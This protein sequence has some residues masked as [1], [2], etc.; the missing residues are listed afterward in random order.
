MSFLRR[1][2]SWITIAGVAISLAGVLA[3]MFLRID[4]YDPSRYFSSL[5]LLRQIKQIDSQWEVQVLRSRIGINLDYDSLVDPLNELNKN[6]RQL[7]QLTQAAPLRNRDKW[8]HNTQ[9]YQQALAKKAELIES[10]K[11]HN[12][13]LR[14]SLH[15]LPTA[16]DDVQNLISD[17]R[18]SMVLDNTSSYVFDVL[19][20]TMEFVQVSTDDKA[21][22]VTIGLE[23][24]EE[25]KAHLDPDTADALD[26]FNQHVH[27]VLRE[28]KV[29][30]GVLNAIAAVSVA[31]RLD[32]L[33]EL[34]SQEQLMSAEQDRLHHQY[35]LVFSG[36]LAALLLYLGVR[37]ARSYGEINR[38]NRALHNANDELEARVV[39]RT[40]ELQ[41]A[42]S[43][44]VG[45]ARQAGMAEIATNVLHNVGNVL[46]SV[47][48][49][50]DL[51]ARK[52]RTSKSAGLSKA[53]AMLQEHQHDLGHFITQ[54]EKGKLLPG[55]FAQVCEALNAERESITRELELLNKSVNHIKEIVTTQQSY[56]GPSSIVEPLMMAEL[57]EDALR[58][59]AGSL[60]RHQVEV[61]RDYGPIAEL[62]LDK[63]R[64]LLILVNLISNAK[65]AMNAREGG[66]R[67]LTLSI[68]EDGERL[69]IRVRDTGEGIDPQHMTRIF[70]HGFTTRAEGH[71]FGLHSC[72][73]AAIEMDGTL[74]VE[75]EG[76]GS[77]ACFVLEIPIKSK[78]Q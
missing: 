12:S 46:N 65:Q 14:N 54:D 62:W 28:Q 2:L 22:E 26:I 43:E 5:A 44:L 8:Q 31:N 60:V 36:V 55:Y 53:V 70:S 39:E 59:Q 64:L 40:R 27:T 48:I 56:A 76:V 68:R 69:T 73:L 29:V 6:W 1:Y 21:A 32:G 33:I 51:V 47:N 37:L 35:L 78:G 18:S 4:S 23:K 34:L 24:L 58:M 16:E 67:T 49:S 20:G 42:Q 30:D 15:F 77:G 13:V 74:R 63:H 50:A 72:A 10:F 11:S 52:V 45:S 25:Q 61:I 71:G 66:P 75:S 3:F 41:R 7:E 17:Q 9:L 57:M 38:V 19:L